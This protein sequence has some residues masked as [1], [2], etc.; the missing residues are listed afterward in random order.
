MS[1]TT[2]NT[3]HDMSYTEASAIFTDAVQAALSNG[4]EHATET[5]LVYRLDMGALIVEYFGT[6]DRLVISEPSG[7]VLYA[8]T[9]TLDGLGVYRWRQAGWAWRKALRG[10]LSRYL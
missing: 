9:G 2:L 6:P 8:A 10:L 1:S 5:G 7:F 4:D 3:A